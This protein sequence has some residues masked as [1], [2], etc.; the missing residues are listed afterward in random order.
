MKIEDVRPASH[1]KT[2]KALDLSDSIQNVVIVLGAV[3]FGTWVV[4][5]LSTQLWIQEKIIPVVSAMMT[6]AGFAAKW[7]NGKAKDGRM[8][9]GDL[10]TDAV[11][12]NPNPGEFAKNVLMSAVEFK[13]FEAAQKLASVAPTVKDTV[14]DLPLS[15]RPAQPHHEQ[16]DG[17]EGVPKTVVSPIE[18]TRDSLTRP[19]DLDE[20]FRLIGDV[21][22]VNTDSKKEFP[23]KL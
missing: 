19:M 23:I 5:P 7:Y 6:G 18:Y 22:P 3:V 14:G 20:E 21:K 13:A 4:L 16:L 15:L 8:R 11:D 2:V 10:F 9:V 1:S 17:I 12:G